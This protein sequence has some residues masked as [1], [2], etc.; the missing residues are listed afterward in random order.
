VLDVHIA[1]RNVVGARIKSAPVR[2][3][4]S[5]DTDAW[6]DRIER[7]RVRVATVTPT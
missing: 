5:S 1:E 3:G 6:A 2:L 4:R 7:G